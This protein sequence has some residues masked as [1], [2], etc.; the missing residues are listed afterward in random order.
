MC[1]R[2]IEFPRALPEHAHPRVE[3]DRGSSAQLDPSDLATRVD[4]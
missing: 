3:S 1:V 2:K 4:L